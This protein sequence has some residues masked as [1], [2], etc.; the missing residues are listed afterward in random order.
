MYEWIYCF[1]HGFCVVRPQSCSFISWGSEDTL[2]IGKVS[3]VLH[4]AG[5]LITSFSQGV[6]KTKDSAAPTR[7]I[8]FLSYVR[9]LTGLWT[10]RY[11]RIPWVS[12]PL[13]NALQL[14]WRHTATDCFLPIYFYWWYFRSFS[15]NTFGR[16][17]N[18]ML[19][20]WLI[21]ALVLR[22][23]PFIGSPVFSFYSLQHS[24]F[25]PV[26]LV[27]ARMY[28]VMHSVSDRWIEGREIDRW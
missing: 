5:E 4:F 26:I 1:G 21:S 16:F 17:S 28:I 11:I 20:E 22:L 24:E 8:Y 14:N 19:F 9:Q 12:M 10:V 6:V 15:I 7:L 18:G 2:L 23:A 27:Y 25:D 3:R 13:N